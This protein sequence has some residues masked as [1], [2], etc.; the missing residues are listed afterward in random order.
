MKKIILKS[1]AIDEISLADVKETEPIFAIGGSKMIGM[2]VKEDKGWIIRTGGDFGAT[3]YHPDK[4]SAIRSASRAIKY[5]YT[6]II[7]PEIK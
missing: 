5:D 6:F 3:G 7:E 4:E 2:L 1:K